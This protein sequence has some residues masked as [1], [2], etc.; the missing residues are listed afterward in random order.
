[1]YVFLKK[2]KV[3]IHVKFPFENLNPS[4]ISHT[5]QVRNSSCVVVLTT[6]EIS[7]ITH[8]INNIIISLNLVIIIKHL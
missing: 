8:A 3:Y 1:M 6:I 4:L 2:K 7:L 5:P